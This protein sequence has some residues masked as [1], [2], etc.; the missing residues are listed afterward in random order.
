ME[1]NTIKEL[2]KISTP[3]QFAKDEYVCYEGQPGSEMYII[4]KGSVGV[5]L[6]SA[7]GTLTEVAQIQQGNFFGE[8]ALFDNLPRSASCIAL[9]D[10]VCVAINKENLKDFLVSCPELVEKM[11]ENLSTR[12]RKLDNDLYK[13][14][15]AVN[16]R[17]VPRFNIPKEYRFSH[18]VKEPYQNPKVLTRYRQACP[19]CG[20]T[21]TVVDLKRN[22]LTFKKMDLDCRI[23]Y[24]M[25]E[26][27]WYDII[28]CPSCYYT[29]H[30]LNF[31]R[32]Y[33]SD[34]ELLQSI[35][36]EEHVPV[37]EQKDA[38]RTSFDRL[39]LKYLQA[40][41]INEHINGNDNAMIGTLWLNLYWLANDS[42]DDSFTLFCA[43]HAVQRFRIAI[44]EDEV[45]DEVSKC[46]IALSLANLLVYIDKA[47]DAAKY[48]TL[49]L[50][51]ADERIKENA[52]TFMET[53]KK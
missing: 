29:N 44:D 8:M 53:L 42:G 9:E 15:C 20:K 13:S 28:S 21:V 2:Q 31:F 27:L 23:E 5:Y 46:S 19:I 12:I 39:V 24:L 10:T 1:A 34:V 11:L 32:I 45:E 49:A 35:L 40:I 50:E 47:Q 26:P 14:T 36:E 16:K 18:V 17:M 25:N 52:K 48:C 6:T 3:K 51:C 22:I 41:N 37:V 33:G 30:H 7:I 4:L 38:K 43:K